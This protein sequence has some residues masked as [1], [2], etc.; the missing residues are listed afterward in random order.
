MR[1]YFYVLRVFRPDNDARFCTNVISDKTT[2]KMLTEWHNGKKPLPMQR[3]QAEAIAAY[4]QNE[5]IRA[6]CVVTGKRLT[7]QP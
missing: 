1:K 5:N 7:E 4:Y 3:K 2:G 6:Y